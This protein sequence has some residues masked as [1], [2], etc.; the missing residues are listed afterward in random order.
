MS[1][2]ISIT[3]MNV[4]FV[5]ISVDFA[6]YD[7]N[8]PIDPAPLLAADHYCLKLIYPKGV[9]IPD[10]AILDVI[11]RLKLECAPSKLAIINGGAGSLSK[12]KLLLWRRW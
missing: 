11:N 9:D 8:R 1:S 12:V 10:N 3:R 4:Y 5:E 7:P 2:L 6:H